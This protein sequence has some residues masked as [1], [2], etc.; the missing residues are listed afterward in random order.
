MSNSA[1]GSGRAMSLWQVKLLLVLH[2]AFHNNE[3]NLEAGAIHGIDV[4]GVLNIITTYRS[5]RGGYGGAMNLDTGTYIT[6]IGCLYAMNI[7]EQRGG[8]IKHR[9]SI[10]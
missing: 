1:G 2:S 8:D 7:A 4:D 6:N 3:D 5:N 9:E 10:L